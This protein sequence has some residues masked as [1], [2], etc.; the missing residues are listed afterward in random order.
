MEEKLVK[1]AGLKKNIVKGDY[2]NPY[3][4]AKIKPLDIEIMQLND[5]NSKELLS[6]AQKQ[7]GGTKRE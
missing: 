5:K 4:T 6:W 2:E 7:A 1:I 3:V